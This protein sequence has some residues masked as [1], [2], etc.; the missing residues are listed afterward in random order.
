MG[1]FAL[2]IGIGEYQSSELQNL[3]AAILDVKAI[4]QV[5]VNPAIADFAQSDV[6][7]LLNPQPQQM[8]ESI[9]RLFVNRRKDDLV[10]LYFS[11]HGLISD[12]SNFH[13][14]CAGTD[15]RILNSTAI[16]AT[17]A[18]RLMEESKSQRQVVILDA[19][20]SGAFAR[21]MKA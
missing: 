14:S 2:L 3:E 21:N 7:V 6:V 15:K 12:D 10:L 18:H 20:F 11:G 5:L 19:C 9:E 13:L 4:E 8:R 17:F 16:P 1:K